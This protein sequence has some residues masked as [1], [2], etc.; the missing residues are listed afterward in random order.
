MGEDE[1]NKDVLARYRLSMDV[2][3]WMLSPKER[4][5]LDLYQSAFSSLLRETPPGSPEQED[6]IAN[7]AAAQVPGS[8]EVLEKVIK[9]AEKVNASGSDS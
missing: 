6:E 5:M 4:K 3:E 9:I 7:R 2:A 1:Q 8:R